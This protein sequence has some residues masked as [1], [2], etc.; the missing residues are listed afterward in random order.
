MKSS[1][2]LVIQTK[3]ASECSVSWTGH[4]NFEGSGDFISMEIHIEGSFY[5]KVPMTLE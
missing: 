4:L 1:E 2:I 3:T 5:Q